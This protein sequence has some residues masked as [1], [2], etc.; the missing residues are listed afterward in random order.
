[1][2]SDPENDWA[3][4]Q[5]RDERIRLLMPSDEISDF[6][7]LNIIIRHISLF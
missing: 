3:K 2:G 4:L 5:T 6:L 7:T 1:M